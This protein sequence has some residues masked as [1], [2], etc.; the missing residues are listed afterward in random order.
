MVLPKG[1]DT[2]AS[3]DSGGDPNVTDQKGNNP[4]TGDMVPITGFAIAALA[5][6]IAIIGL[7]DSM[8]KRR[9]KS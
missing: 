6:S 4:N 7:L 1:T 5:A 3:S 2:G 8:V 9:K